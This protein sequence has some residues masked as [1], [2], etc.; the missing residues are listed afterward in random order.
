MGA[1]RHSSP[2][3]PSAF[4]GRQVELDQVVTLLVRSVRLITLV[5]PGG[6]GKTRLA[7]EAV[8]RFRRSAG[9]SVHWVRLA[10]L[11][12]G[13]S[14]TAVEEE[15]A[16]AV[17]E[18]DFSPRSGWRAIVDALS[19][20]DDSEQT[21]LVMD[22]CEHVLGAAGQV[23]DRLLAAAPNLSIVAT[24]RGT[25]GWIDEY[26]V[27]VPPLTL[28]QGVE[29]FQLRSE[30]VGRPMLAGERDLIGQICRHVDNHPLY[31]RLAAACL[32]RKPLPV[33][34]AELSGGATDRRMRWSD[35]PR[36]GI[37]PRHRGVRDV[38]AWS[39]ELCDEPE[40]ILFERMAVFAAGYDANPEEGD[41]DWLDIG[42]DREAIIAVCS[43][44]DG[45]SGP[46]T[47]TPESIPDLLDRLVDQSLV[48]IHLT[49]TTA[50][51][52][53][54]ESIRVF[55]QYRLEQRS[56]SGSDERARLELRHL[57]YY[58]DKVV[59]AAANWCGPDEIKYLE[60]ARAAWTNVLTAMDRSLAEPEHAVLALDICQGLLEI[61]LQFLG[62]SFREIRVWS[63]RV[64][65][66]VQQRAATAQD[67]ESG[68]ALEVTAQLVR[69]AV[70]QSAHDD[71]A[72]LLDECM[73][74]I[75]GD[76]VAPSG[77]RESAGA[78]LRAAAA[79][80]CAWGLELLMAKQDPRS[81]TVLDRAAA[82]YEAEGKPGSAV[83]AGLFGALAAGALGTDEEAESLTA[84]YLEKVNRSGA[85]WA[86]AWAQLARALALTRVGRLNEALK[87]ERM[88][89]ACMIRIRDQFGALWAVQFRM[90]TLARII[91]GIRST[92]SERRQATAIAAEIAQLAGG[93][94]ALVADLRI[95][96]SGLGPFS[97]GT[98]DAIAI[99]RETLGEHGFADARAQGTKLR[100]DR[101]E[102]QSLAMGKMS[103]RP[104]APRSTSMWSQL[105]QAE[106]AVATLA[107][108]GWTNSAI[109][110]RRGSS[111]RTVDSQVASVLRKLSISSREQIVDLVPPA[112]QERVR[113]EALRRSERQ[114]R[115]SP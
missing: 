50:R 10:R 111:T 83:A 85:P 100:I 76:Q 110:V 75:A 60:W 3:S 56:A 77:W 64:L 35:A 88:A 99:A 5:G 58:R 95:D 103:L 98:S 26:R 86:F 72:E 67:R 80:E 104:P 94:E 18:T 68:N 40:Q 4:V 89:L 12:P 15:I 1:R 113:A 78:D 47:V 69:I 109:S 71:A 17:M 62:C 22:N 54:L 23:I 37:D 7:A 39:Y 114:S 29:L 87:M 55:A 112:L 8:N 11:A 105:S 61:R 101:R 28:E 65:T 20:G 52:S 44:P 27:P 36:V 79:V 92:P 70:C 16:H 19:G 115:F 33:I 96:V 84:T 2:T 106:A 107:A 42:A 82:K 6:I 73:R 30:L 91:E 102:L 81:V 53:L 51:Y 21:V 38:I 25:I 34:L 14:V 90:L 66:A 57:Q 43:D 59:A 108:A 45:S 31:I 24:S 63:G 49:S 32:A 46:G 41:E 97:A 48:S 93:I 74:I 9:A 13:S